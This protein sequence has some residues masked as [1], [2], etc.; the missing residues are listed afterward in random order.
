MTGHPF[1]HWYIYYT[2]RR[3]R[4]H[5]ISVRLWR[6]QNTITTFYARALTLTSL[7]R[8]R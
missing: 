2:S 6:T 5:P 8:Q 1:P 3:R 4:R 7:R